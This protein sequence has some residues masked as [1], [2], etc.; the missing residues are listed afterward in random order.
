MSW[1]DACCI[2]IDDNEWCSLLLFCIIFIYKK[3]VVL[4]L[5]EKAYIKSENNKCVA[6]HNSLVTLE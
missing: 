3:I 2:V 4:F 1:C 6:G 5:D